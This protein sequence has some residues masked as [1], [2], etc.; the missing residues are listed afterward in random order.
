MNVSVCDDIIRLESK[1][2]NLMNLRHPCISSTMLVILR[3]PLQGLQIVQ[4][5]SSGDS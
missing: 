3:S 2:E 5:Y 1:I 4:Q